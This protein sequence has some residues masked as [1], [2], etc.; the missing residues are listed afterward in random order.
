VPSDPDV[1]GIATVI[2]GLSGLGADELFGGYPSFRR[3]P[4]WS[5]LVRS[6]KVVPLHMWSG[7]I[8]RLG[9][10]DGR[11]GGFEKLADLVASV[12][13]RLHHAAHSR[14]DLPLV[15]YVWA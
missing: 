4:R 13:H 12:D 10:L 2:V 6:F 7:L 11:T 14:L 9:T 3:A 5:Q 8:A 15:N 1:A